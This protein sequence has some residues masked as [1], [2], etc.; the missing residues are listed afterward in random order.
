MCRCVLYAV[1]DHK[2]KKKRIKF[3]AAMHASESS[4]IAEEVVVLLR[5]LHPLPAWNDLI[6]KFIGNS[7]QHIPNIIMVAE[8]NRN[9]AS[10][11]VRAQV[12]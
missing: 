6:N 5:R 1:V 3:N 10:S 9:T 4:T 8:E 12:R 11:D 7:L 2:S